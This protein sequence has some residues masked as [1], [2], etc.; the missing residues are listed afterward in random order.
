MRLCLCGALLVKRHSESCA[1]TQAV[2]NA[3]PVYVCETFLTEEARSK[4]SEARICFISA[5]WLVRPLG[6]DCRS[7]CGSDNE[8]LTT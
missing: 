1:L 3:G 5:S 7:V 4:Y 6:S 8:A 2:V